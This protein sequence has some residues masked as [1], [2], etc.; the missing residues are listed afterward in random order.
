MKHFVWLSFDLG[1]KGDYEGMYAWLDSHNAK[2]CG[3]SVACFWY[4]HAGDLLQNLQD[5]LKANVELDSKKNRIYVIRLA[6]GKMKGNFI[7]GRRRN[8]PWSGYADTGEQGD[9]ASS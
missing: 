2:E 5:D 8:S 7:F 6:E 9:D 1:V 3:D 4:E